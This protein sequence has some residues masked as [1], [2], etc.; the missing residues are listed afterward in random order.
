MNDQHR[1]PSIDELRAVSQPPSVRGRKN[2]EHWSGFYMRDGSVRLTRLLVPT[3]ATPNGVTGVM[4][5]TGWC[6]GLSLLIPGILGPILAVFFGQLQ[7]YLDAVDGEL[8]R[9]RQRFSPA[10]IFLDRVAHYTTEGFVGLAIGLRAAG[11]VGGHPAG[12]DPWKYAFF[13]ALLMSGILLNKALNDLVHVA[14]SL[15]GLDRLPDTAEAKAVPATSA[16][17]M[18]RKV[19]RFLPFYR[20]FHSV[21]LGLVCLALAIVGLFAGDQQVFRVSVIVLA[22]LVWLSVLGHFLAIMASSRVKA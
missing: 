3:R 15:S 11:V 5:L 4:I 22:V 17:G 1:R 13:G 20:I 9:W 18:A 14:R 16:I 12:V 21:D 19:F 10:G 7:M 6:I 8:A 2:A